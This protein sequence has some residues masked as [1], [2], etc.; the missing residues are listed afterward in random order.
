[1]GFL[2][3]QELEIA[4]RYR[5]PIG[6]LRLRVRANRGSD[7]FIF[8]EV[9]EHEYYDLGLPF[10]PETILDLGGNAGFTAVYFERVYP[11]ARI[12]V[13]EPVPEN[14]RVLRQN[15]E[16]N[17]PAVVVLP[18]AVAVTDGPIRM[19]LGVLDYGH[20]IAEPGASLGDRSI[21][22]AGVSIPTMMDRLGWARIGLLKVDIEGYEKTLFAA[23]PEW[24]RLVDAMCIECHDGFGRAD[25]DDIAERF[26][27]GRPVQLPGI[28]LLV[29]P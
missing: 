27:F 15:V 1:M 11:G 19:E 21:E 24:L 17:A 12:A 7:G 18:S 6:A 25:L 29:R 14:L 8:G 2:C 10:S 5:D 3:P 20:R 23:E 22:V 26:G 13:V 4:F 28:W 16:V 9:F